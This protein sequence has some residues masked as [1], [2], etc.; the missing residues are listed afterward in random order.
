MSELGRERA[1]RLPAGRHGPGPGRGRRCVVDRPARQPAV[2]QRRSRSRCSASPATPSTLAGRPCPVA[3]LRRRATARKVERPGRAG[4]ARPAPG[5]ARSR[6]CGATARA[7]FV[8]AHAVPLRHASGGDIDGIVIIA[9]RGRPGATSQRERDRIGLLERIGERL[10]GS[11]ELDAHAAARRARRWSRSSPITASSTC[12]SGDKL[13]RRAQMQRARL[14][15]AAGHLGAGRRA[16]HLPGRALLPAGDGAAGHGRGRG[17]ATERVLPGAAAPES[18]RASA[19]GRADLGD[20]GAAVRPGRT[21]RRDEPGPVRA[22]RARRA[23]LRRGRPRPR[24]R[25]SP[26]GSPSRST[27]RCCSRRS[28]APRWRSRPACCRSDPPTLDGL[29][30]AYRY[31][32]AKPL[33]THGQG[34]QTQVGGDWYDIIPLSA[35]RVGIVIGDVEGPRRPGGGDHG[36]AA[37]R[38]AGVRPGRQAARGHPAQARRLVPDAGR[39][40]AEAR[41]RRPATRP[42][43]AAPT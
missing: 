2:R 38:A 11:L 43:S 3:R 18:M 15:A 19:G 24:R 13:I 31:V 25:R 10:A 28:G 20:R 8:R 32:P 37:R 26:A 42:P 39:T 14:D 22:D 16:D 33:E 35:G 34:I 40:A 27:T 17:P 23:P 5:R 4:A 29:E 36:P 6:A 9:R 1:R 7:C 41:R 30:V 21:A 12:S